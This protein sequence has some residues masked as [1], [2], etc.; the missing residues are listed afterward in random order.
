ML[1]KII[2]I[3]IFIVAG[4][5]MY[6]Q[7]ANDQKASETTKVDGES[8]ETL[9]KQGLEIGK[10]APDI[11]LVSTTGERVSLSNFKGKKVIVNFWATWC[12]PCREE[13][14]ELQAFYEKKSNSAVLLA[15]NYTVS[16]RTN[17]EEKV[18]KYIKEE[19]FTFPVLLDSSS[20]AV[21]TY[22]VISLPT[23]YFIDTTGIIRQKYIGMMT[24]SFIEQTLSS[25][26]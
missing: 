3:L 6:Q 25:I 9:L 2:I 10:Q 15:V 24:T 4:F 8:K 22:Q 11:T 1:R 17:G 21:N 7:L 13:M 18:R 5:A 12:P 19:G 20:I 16:E 23:S 26:P 14:P